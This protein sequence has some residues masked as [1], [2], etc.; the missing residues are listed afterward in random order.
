MASKLRIGD[1]I[2][3]ADARRLTRGTEEVQLSPK[4]FA[5]LSI[6]L[7]QR[8]RAL[9]KEELHRQLWPAT[10]VSDT[11]LA[12]LIG[13]IR[14]ALGDTARKPRYVR[15]AHRF[16]YAF[17]GEV[18]D[19]GNESDQAPFC[20]LIRDRQRLPL[21]GGENVIGRDRGGGIHIESVTVSRRHARI[22]ISGNGAVIEDLR[23]K[24]GTFVDGKPI[25]VPTPLADGVEIRTGSIAFRFRMSSPTGSTATW[26]TSG[27]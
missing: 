26:S 20:W 1:R 11:S 12:T 15:T 7:D 19:S 9:S 13:E 5:L 27:D 25:T 8:P 16:G 3:D 2:F 23:S 17:C 14:V 24:N 4:A 6:L 21:A 18:I 22:V 10:F